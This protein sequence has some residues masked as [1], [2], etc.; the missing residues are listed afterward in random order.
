[1]EKNEIYFKYTPNRPHKQTP[2]LPLHSSK[3]LITELHNLNFREK[4]ENLHDFIINIICILSSN[5]LKYVIIFAEG[6]KAAK[7]VD[8]VG[9]DVVNLMLSAMYYV[10]REYL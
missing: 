4:P 6:E 5:P 8:D 3:I 1:L 7:C 2:F 10:F 9:F